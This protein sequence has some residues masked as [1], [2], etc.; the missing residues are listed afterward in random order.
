MKIAVIIVMIDIQINGI[1]TINM[2]L[3]SICSILW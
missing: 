1:F 3:K 2:Q